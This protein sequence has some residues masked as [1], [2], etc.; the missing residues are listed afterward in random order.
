MLQNLKLFEGQYGAISEKYP[1]D[2]MWQDVVKMQVHSTQFIQ[3]SQR[4]NDPLGLL[5][6]GDKLF[7]TQNS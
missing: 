2:F 7:Y 1:P 6:F 4:K 5:S 3:Y